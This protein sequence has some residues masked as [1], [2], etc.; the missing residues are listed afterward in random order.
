MAVVQLN[1][2][3]D[4]EKKRGRRKREKFLQWF[5]HYKL[6]LCSQTLF[7]PYNLHLSCS[8]DPK[9]SKD[10]KYYRLNFGKTFK[11]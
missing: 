3:E 9:V 4:E 10:T 1:E 5:S 7:N 11:K 2:R 6:P 8:G